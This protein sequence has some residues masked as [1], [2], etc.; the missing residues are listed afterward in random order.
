MNDIQEVIL[1]IYRVVENLC[2]KHDIPFYAVGGTC[3]GAI[4]HHGFIPWDDDLD[5]AIPIQYYDQFWDI[6]E[7]E[8]PHHLKVYT[9]ENVRNYRYIFGKIH[10][11][12]T[13]F[14]EKSELGYHDAYKGVFI[15]IMP[16]SSIPDDEYKR[17]KFYEKLL[18]YSQLNY[19]RRYPYRGM[20]TLKRK[21]AW[22]M[23][24]P[25]CLVISSDYYSEKWLNMLRDN[26]LGSSSLTGYTWSTQVRRL[27][28]PMIDFESTV[29][30]PFEDTIIKCPV[31]YHDYLTI[32]FGDYMKLP[33]EDQRAPHH[34]E[35]I[36]I[37]KSYINYYKGVAK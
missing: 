32:Q 3:I 8:L 26:P 24:R 18:K 17:E 28:F 37:N 19:I 10:N 16:L 6:A 34:T 27:T 25:L 30:L 12:N 35:T 33:P 1:D 2:T 7:K 29:N 4:R 11:R 23:M 31:N 14:I 9:C 21:I 20:D 36:D 13:T 15:D 22:I 5:I